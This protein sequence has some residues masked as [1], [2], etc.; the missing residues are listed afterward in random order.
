MEVDY[1][2][3][4]ECTNERVSG[5]G[6]YVHEAQGIATAMVVDGLGH[7]PL[8]AEAAQKTCGIM[9]EIGGDPLPNLI[10]T[11]HVALRGTRGA[12]IGIARIHPERHELRFIGVGNIS[13][14]LVRPED[15]SRSLMS[16]PGIIGHEM[17]KPREMSYP[18]TERT[19]LVLNTDGLQTHGTASAYPWALA[20]E[21]S[22]LAALLYRDWDRGRDDV[23]V[24]T[25]KQRPSRSYDR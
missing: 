7:G 24:L 20:S 6:Y 21:A 11:I 19:I 17:L 25:L 12:A 16:Y 15:A 8:A 4:L 3:Q 22:L 13:G 5:D 18:W 23:T 14:T 1:G 2:G 10:D 9:Q